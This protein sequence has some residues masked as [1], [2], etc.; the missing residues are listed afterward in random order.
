MQ[1]R[2]IDQQDSKVP[3]ALKHKLSFQR[4]MS[5]WINKSILYFDWITFCS[6][7]SLRINRLIQQLLK[8]QQK[9]IPFKS[10]WSW[11]SHAWP[12]QVQNTLRNFGNQFNFF[13]CI[14]VVFFFG[15]LDIGSTIQNISFCIYNSWK[16]VFFSPLK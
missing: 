3:N 10:W 9:S 1:E 7:H 6:A 11:S 16:F 15:L 13:S 4:K 5:Q 8:Q 14:W 2:F 12:T